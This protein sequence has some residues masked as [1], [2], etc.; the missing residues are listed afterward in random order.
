MLAGYPS[1]AESPLRSAPAISPVC[2]RHELPVRVPDFGTTFGTERSEFGTITIEPDETEDAEAIDLEKTRAGGEKTKRYL[3]D[4]SCLKSPC[5][6]ILYR[7]S[8]NMSDLAPRAGVPFGSYVVGTDAGDGWLKVANR[9]YLPK[10]INAMPVLLLTWKPGATQPNVFMKKLL[11]Q[12]LSDDALGHSARIIIQVQR[13]EHGESGFTVWPDF[14]TICCKD[15]SRPELHKMNEG[16]LVWAVDGF[17]VPCFSD[18]QRYA[19]GISAFTLTLMRPEDPT[20]ETDQE[21]CLNENCANTR[22]MIG[23]MYCPACG[24]RRP[25]LE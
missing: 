20:A 9:M 7:R 13:N 6:G 24:A 19:S 1:A 10:K 21:P 11:A 8:K 18:Y 17:R 12:K 5:K 2:I 23:A 3:V 4:N 14:M 15:R 16:D 25:R 22:C